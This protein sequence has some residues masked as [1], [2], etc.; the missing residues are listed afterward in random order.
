MNAGTA[1][2]WIGDFLERAQVL[3]PDEDRPRWLARDELQ[4]CYRSGGLPE[5]TVYLACELLLVR[6]DPQVERQRARELKRAK[7]ASQPLQERSAGCIFKNPAP[8]LPAGRLVDECG[9]K[10]WRQGDA[11]VSPRHANFIVNR[12]AASAV[13]IFTLIQRVRAHVW[14]ERAVDLQVE[15]R[16]WQAPVAVHAPAAEVEA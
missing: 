9:C 10:D 13:D 5:G 1:H 3:L 15:V 11:V 16:T 4:P 7:A 6:G 2:C 8:E 12:G 14:R